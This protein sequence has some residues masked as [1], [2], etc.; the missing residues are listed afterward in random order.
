MSVNEAKCLLDSY[1]CGW[2]HDC[3][4]APNRD[5]DAFPY[6]QPANC[7]KKIIIIVKLAKTNT[8]ASVRQI[9]FNITG[10]ITI[11]NFITWLQ[12]LHKANMAKLEVFG[13][14]VRLVRK[15]TINTLNQAETK[16]SG[17]KH[18]SYN[19]FNPKATFLPITVFSRAFS[20]I[21]WCCFAKEIK[22]Q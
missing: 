22:T 7:K 13:L 12:S 18:R 16:C 4:A 15:Q 2:R 8:S 19:H 6:W 9:V 21:D 10:T 20:K 1:C 3:L 14:T 17:S 11:S 5:S